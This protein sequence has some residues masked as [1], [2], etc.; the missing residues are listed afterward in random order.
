MKIQETEEAVKAIKKY[1]ITKQYIKVKK[2]IEEG[3]YLSVQLKKRKPKNKGIWYFR[4]TKKFRAFAR[5][6]NEI[7]VVY[8]ID[9]HQ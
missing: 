3:N 1:G 7:L 9:D 4:I 5:I 8:H 2:Y 6:K